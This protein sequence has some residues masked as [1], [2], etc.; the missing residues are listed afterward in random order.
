MWGYFMHGSLAERS[1]QEGSPPFS[2]RL[3]HPYPKQVVGVSS[4]TCRRTSSSKS[5]ASEIPLDPVIKKTM[6]VHVAKN[7][8][9]LSD[10]AALESEQ[11]Q[12]DWMN[13]G[14]ADLP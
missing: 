4:T 2:S 8:G 11:A 13:P 12:S 5:D 6:E 9:S 14:R 7:D 3:R 1:A 10:K